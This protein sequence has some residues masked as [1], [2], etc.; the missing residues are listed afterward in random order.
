MGGDVKF[1]N[2]DVEDAGL[3]H[4]AQ[5]PGRAL[6]ALGDG[7][8]IEVLGTAQ[9]GTA[10]PRVAVAQRPDG[11]GPVALGHGRLEEGGHT[12][13]GGGVEPV[14]PAGELV[15]DAVIRRIQHRVADET[16]L[17]RGNPGG[18]GGEGCGRRRRKSRVD[19]G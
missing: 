19:D 15:D 17:P 8:R 9:H 5:P 6:H 12:L 7:S 13:P 18:Q 4:L 10:E 1:G 3:P 16:V 11:S 14:V 2:V